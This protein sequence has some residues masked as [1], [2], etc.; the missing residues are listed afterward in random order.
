ME[1]ITFNN[2]MPVL[3]DYGMKVRNLYQDNLIERDGIASGKLLNT[4]EFQVSQNGME[5]EVSLTLQ[6]YWKYLEYGTKPHW[7][8]VSKLLEWVRIKPVI[9]RPDAEGRIPTP[10]SLAYLIGRKIAK[11]GTR[12]R[13]ALKDAID[14]VN[15]EYADKLILALVADTE[16]YI[17][18]AIVGL[19]GSLD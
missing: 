8:P 12:G 13:E 15:A 11:F 7:P 3:E 17:A 10:E 14:E 9:P 4:V 19:Q 16:D 5:F 6:D 2:L 18:K 1:L